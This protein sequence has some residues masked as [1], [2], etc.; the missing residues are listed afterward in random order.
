[1]N[2]SITYAQNREDLIIAGFLKGVENG[3]Y[4]DVGASYPDVFSVTKRFY[5]SGWHGINIEPS[6]HVF[7]ELQLKRTRDVNL[8]VG[9]GSDDTFKIFREYPLG[10]GLST[11]SSKMRHQHEKSD[12]PITA[13]YNDAEVRVRTLKSVF[14]EYNVSHIDFMKIDVEG[15]EYD[16][17]IGND[18]EQYR[19]TL[20]CIEA[21][22]RG[23]DW[24]LLLERAAYTQVFY[25]GLNEYF[26]ANESLTLRDFF[27][28]PESVLD[29]DY[30][31][32]WQYQTIQTCKGEV[33]KLKQD[34]VMFHMQYAALTDHANEL[35]KQVAD[36][37]QAVDELE[38]HVQQSG[39]VKNSFRIFLRSV[40][41]A[42]HAYLIRFE[43]HFVKRNP[44][45]HEKDTHVINLSNKRAEL[46]RAVR[47][48]DLWI[49]VVQPNIQ[50]NNPQPR[51]YT[52][53]VAYTMFVRTVAYVLK[54]CWHAL[55]RLRK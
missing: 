35:E 16:V 53:D 30:L 3:F 38:Y 36:M 13:T 45:E 15:Y 14:K 41:A 12:E 27:S 9:I 18:W 43:G 46:L 48:Y 55:R 20:L 21:N 33:R 19:P 4:V 25:D 40:D 31:A 10:D 44:E 26:L 51:R 50:H 22:R 49:N 52:L 37:R 47:E 6:S 5:M 11:F 54:V 23:R 7:N 28:F 1:M 32:F 42:I 17:I 8:N 24:R 39:R 29:R 2:Y 34:Q